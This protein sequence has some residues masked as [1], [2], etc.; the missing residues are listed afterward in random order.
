M[1]D[2]LE[3]DSTRLPELF[4]QVQEIAG[5]YVDNLP[6]SP[7]SLGTV[8]PLSLAL[9]TEGVGAEATI[10]AFLAQIKPLLVTT[11]GPATWVL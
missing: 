6:S 11:T 2:Q 3:Q 8:P 10:G 4:R 7:T 9:P 5:Q 1:N